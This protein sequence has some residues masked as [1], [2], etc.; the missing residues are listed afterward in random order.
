MRMDDSV[1]DFSVDPASYVLF[2]EREDNGTEVLKAERKVCILTWLK[3]HI[4]CRHA[5]SLS[6]IIHELNCMEKIDGDLQT[7]LLPK[8]RSYNRNHAIGSEIFLATNQMRTFV[9]DSLRAYVPSLSNSPP[10]PRTERFDRIILARMEREEHTPFDG[11]IEGRDLQ[12]LCLLT[13]VREAARSFKQLNPHA[14]P[15][16]DQKNLQVFYGL[17]KAALQHECKYPYGNYNLNDP[18]V[19]EE[20]ANDALRNLR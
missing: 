5:Y 14:D 18:N 13:F 9:V 10:P 17:L 19:I 20:L 11:G 6:R 1:R 16:R 8:V 15:D 7:A 12:R 4:F 3:V 2:V